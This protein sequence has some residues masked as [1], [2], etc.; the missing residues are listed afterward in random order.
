MRSLLQYATLAPSSHNTQPW[1]FV[2]GEGRIALYADR[3]RALPAN[4]PQDRELTI[5]CGCAVM[6]LRVAAAR[7]GLSARVFPLP[8]P[9]NADWL[10]VVDLENRGATPDEAELFPAISRRHT[11]RQPFEAREVPGMLL[12][13]LSSTANREGAWLEFLPEEE[14]PEV[15]R[16]IAEGNTAQWSN[17][18]WRRELAVWMRPRR[19]GDGL[20]VPGLLAPAIR[21]VVR[22]FDMAKSVAEGDRKLA[23]NAP[24]LAVLGSDSEGVTDWLRTG[25]ALERVLLE[26]A[27]EGLQAS[28]LNQ[29]IQVAA[30]RP[31]LQRLVNRDGYP[32]I[33]LRLGFPSGS[34]RATPRRGLDEVVQ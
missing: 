29:P 27:R 16:L 33:L 10:C 17:P 1:R 12:Q 4:D 7:A 3:T 8:D 18:A 2:Y 32:Q 28:Y 15:S 22:H 30:L 19:R 6:N 9:G 25:Q 26:A 34:M 13:G 5:S 23:E 20:T 14:R 11:Y 31:R 21:M 24:V